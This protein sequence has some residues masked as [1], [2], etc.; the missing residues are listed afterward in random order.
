MA[1][2]TVATY[3]P[4]E[5]QTQFIAYSRDDGYTFTFFE[6]NPV[7][8][9]GSSQ[10][11]D[12]Y[13]IW[14]EDHWA[15]VVAYAMEFT[16][17]VFTSPDLKTWTHASNFTHYGLLGLQYECPNLVEVPVDGTDDTMYLLQIS[18]N[19]GAPY[20]G[21]ISQY[22]LGDFDGYQ[23]Q[24]RDHATR[25]SDFAKDA[26]AGQFF[27]G[28]PKGQAV[29]MNWASNW[30]YTQ[31]VPTGPAEG[32]RSAMGI[33][34]SI[35][36]REVERIGYVEV[37]RPYNLGPI[38]GDV[39]E[40]QTMSNGSFVVD[41]SDVA[42]NA[43]HVYVNVT[44]LPA[45]AN[46]TGTMNLTFSS[47]VT[48]EYLQT[49]TFFGGDAA[50]AINRGGLR[51]F[52]NIY[53][54]DKFS[55]AQLMQDSWTFEAILD[56]SVY[57]TFLDDGAASSTSVF[58]PESPLTTL[59]FGVQGLPAGNMSVDVT[60]TAL[61]RSWAEYENEQGTVLGNVSTTAANSTY[62][63]AHAKVDYRA[64]FRL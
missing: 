39:L 33:P 59:S 62:G 45:T 15:M 3:E 24:P 37:A 55:Q 9:I 28:L 42:S 38:L 47:P 17:G 4:I 61:K 19:P 30:Q 18:I 12:P 56:R 16:I 29:S 25:I 64:A 11:R 6:G 2:F 1:I 31:Q 50:V 63:K 43:L 32:W 49:A 44:G 40:Q 46:R 14:H 8:D 51:G 20:G 58:Y 7:L 23:F 21:S 22:F 53:F 36:V 60:V 5:L 52:E 27:G 48:G 26:Y 13:V 10:F 41:F 34:R 35:S 57:E 54:T